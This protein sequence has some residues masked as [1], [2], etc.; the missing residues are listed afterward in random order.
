MSEGEGDIESRLV[1]LF[2]QYDI[3]H[4]GYLSLSS[5]LI[6]RNEGRG[7]KKDKGG[8]KDEKNSTSS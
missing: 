8:E 2:N 1:D 3:D 5:F 6:K 7:R 4:D